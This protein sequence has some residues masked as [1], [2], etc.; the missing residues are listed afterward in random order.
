MNVEEK[1]IAD[2]E[3]EYFAL[4]PPTQPERE[5]GKTA[6]GDLFG[7]LKFADLPKRKQS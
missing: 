5:A 2:R 3:L 4:Q 1:A 6:Q 7:G